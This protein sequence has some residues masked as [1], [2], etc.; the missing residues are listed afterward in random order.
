MKK[1]LISKLSKFAL[2]PLLGFSL[3]STIEAQSKEDYRKKAEFTNYIGA[4][5][6]IG[7]SKSEYNILNYEDAQ[8]NNLTKLDAYLKIEP[9]IK[10][11]RFEIG[12]P[13]QASLTNLSYFAKRLIKTGDYSDSRY[14][15][16]VFKKYTPSF[17]ILA[18]IPFGKFD[19]KWGPEIQ[20]T[21]FY[22][23]LIQREMEKVPCNGNNPNS[24]GNINLS[25]KTID[26]ESLGINGWSNRL[27]AGIF[28]DNQNNNS[29]ITISPYIEKT[30][31][32]LEGGISLDIKY[33]R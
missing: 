17:G 21:T 15:E 4:G 31:K 24:C 25:F 11:E 26:Q 29:T 9:T 10:K 19:T 2:I 3:N 18:R 33:D 28:F 14:K 5:I 6:N 30:R 22:Y 1:N 13:I 7:G 20:F 12:F 8:K 27:S 16:I 23:S 32:Y